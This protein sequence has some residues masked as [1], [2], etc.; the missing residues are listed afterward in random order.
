MHLDNRK[1]EACCVVLG[2]LLI[3]FKYWGNRNNFVPSFLQK[4]RFFF[5]SILTANRM[6]VIAA[7][8]FCAP[9]CAAAVSA[10]AGGPILGAV[11][12]VAAVGY[13]VYSFATKKPDNLDE[14]KFED[15]IEDD[16]PVVFSPV[17]KIA[18]H[19]QTTESQSTVQSSSFL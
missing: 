7:A 4:F 12:M 10:I 1:Y 14:E 16:E 11:G 6:E 18:K 13:S 19:P 9:G 15:A 17:V 3:E 5:I 8:G 2:L